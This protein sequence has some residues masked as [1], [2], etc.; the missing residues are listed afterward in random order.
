MTTNGSRRKHLNGAQALAFSR[1]RY[2]SET[3]DRTRGENQ[4]RVIEAIITKMSNPGNLLNYQKI[5]SSLTD[6]S[7]TSMSSDNITTLINT[8][9]N[10]MDKWTTRSISVT[11]TDSHNYTYSMGNMMLYVMEPDVSSINIAKQKIQQY[12]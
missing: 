10:S 7:Q 3:G 5:L 11:G 2:S 1:E 12:Q 8:Q 6:A 9:L 4:E